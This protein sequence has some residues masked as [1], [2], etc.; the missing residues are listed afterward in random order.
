MINRDT[1][2][3]IS[4]IYINLLA[5]CHDILSKQNS[6]FI[7][8]KTVAKRRFR[9]AAAFNKYHK[10]RN[11]SL[12]NFIYIE[13]HVYSIYYTFECH[14]SYLNHLTKCH[15]RNTIKQILNVM[16]SQLNSTAT[17]TLRC[18]VRFMAAHFRIIKIWSGRKNV[19]WLTNNN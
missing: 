6:F 1:C 10:E 19:H 11:R 12:E 14:H 9:A 13:I 17:N 2:K 18:I 16:L 7:R 8:V 4:K 15:E 5:H 3:L